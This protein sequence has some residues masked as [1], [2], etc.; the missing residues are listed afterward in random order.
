MAS[1]TPETTGAH[2]ISLA[3]PHARIRLTDAPSSAVYT[4]SPDGQDFLLWSR[5]GTLVAQKFNVNSLSL[6]GEPYPLVESVG[7]N[8]VFRL[9]VAASFGPALLFEPPR[10]SHL[11]WLDRSGKTMGA[12]GS[13]GVYR[14][15]ILSHDGR[16]VAV[17]RAGDDGRI[18]AWLLD[19]ERGTENRFTGAGDYRRPDVVGG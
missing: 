3:N 11:V 8:I 18:E 15:L 2:A 14:D 7:V 6:S 12:L 1:H 16:R 13:A 9:R 10:K 17:S 4:R 19:T 5:S